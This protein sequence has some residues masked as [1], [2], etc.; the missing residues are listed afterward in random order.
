MQEYRRSLKNRMNRLDRLKGLKQCFHGSTTRGDVLDFSTNMYPVSLP[1]DVIAEMVK[2]LD[3]VSSYPDSE[4]RELRRRI[5]GKHSVP[6]ESVIVGN[7]CTELIRLIAF[8]FGDGISFIPQPTFGEYEYSVL[9][10]GGSVVSAR[11]PEEKNFLLTEEVLGEM[12]TNTKLVFLCNPN[13][14]TG[15]FIPEKT[16]YSFLEET[17]NKD[18][19]VVVDEVYCELSDSISLIEKTVEFENLVVLRSLTKAYGLCGLRLGYAVAD[20]KTIEVLDKA[21]PPW[22]VNVIAQKAALA[23]IN[24]PCV[25]KIKKEAKNGKEMLKR[26]LEKLP[27]KV[28]PSE[29]N[30]LLINIR[31]TGYGSSE[32]TEQL[33]EEGVYIRDCSSF[34][35][36]DEKYVRVGVKTPKDNKILVE[37]LGKVLG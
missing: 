37:K 26:D 14:P 13:N 27:L 11:I 1:N 10:Y 6:L 15:R 33:L 19:L 8:C 12:P 5:S 24:H 31:E 2:A 35:Y 18:I 25:Q 34:P 23:C 4:T 16:V 29:A 36:L 3:G 7:G 9:L 32:L 20:E 22:N 30:F 28:Y 17:Q 21:R